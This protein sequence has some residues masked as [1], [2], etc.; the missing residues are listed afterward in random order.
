[1]YCVRDAY[2]NTLHFSY[3]ITSRRKW[4]ENWRSFVFHFTCSHRCQPGHQR[5]RAMKI[6]SCR[7]RPLNKR[8]VRK[9]KESGVGIEEVGESISNQEKEANWRRM[10]K[11][12]VNGWL[13]PLLHPSRSL[14]F[15]FFLN[16]T[17]EEEKMGKWK[18]KNE[19]RWDENWW[20]EG[21]IGIQMLY[22][23]TVF[24]SF[25]HRHRFDMAFVLLVNRFTS[26]Y[27]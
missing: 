19:L 11:N 1:M 13:T 20:K 15:S 23:L 6:K 14:F 25:H 8:Y 27:Y 7:A 5:K 3:S 9:K 24:D 18:I 22:L 21:S 16:Q 26:D 17:E 2:T 10:T 4:I 12:I